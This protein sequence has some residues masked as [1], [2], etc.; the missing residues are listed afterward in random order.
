MLDVIEKRR[1]VRRFLS[2]AIPKQDVLEILESG[3]KAPSSK[4]RQPWKFVVVQGKAKEQM[5]GVFRQGILREET[6]A[7]LL[8]QSRQYIAG[9]KATVKAM[10]QAPVIIFVVNPLENGFLANQSFE[11]QVYELCNGQSVGAAIENMLLSATEKG[12][13][14]LWICDTFFA[15]PELCQWLDIEGK[16]LAA[17]A[18]GYPDE[19][20]EARPRK[21]LEEIVEWRT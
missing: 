2:R 10:E 17:V 4:N 20:P 21:K 13:G 15:Y 16:L 18:L 14:S 7:S 6:E 9:A 19:F 12:I 5:I 3:M 8:P 1:S 11:Q